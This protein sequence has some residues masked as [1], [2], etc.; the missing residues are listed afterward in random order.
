MAEWASH[1]C[2]VVGTGAGGEDWSERRG[3]YMY[4][5]GGEVTA[6]AVGN[7][8]AE[9]SRHMK[10]AAVTF[11]GGRYSAQKRSDSGLDE[12]A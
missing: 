6:A 2:G 9:V 7:E 1:G 12:G 3:S 11:G 4:G 10:R 8:W 5:G